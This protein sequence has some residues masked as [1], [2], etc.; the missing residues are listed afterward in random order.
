MLVIR[1]TFSSRTLFAMIQ[2]ET[3]LMRMMK[4]PRLMLLPLKRTRSLG[5]RLRVG[6]LS[7]FLSI[8]CGFM[9]D[10]FLFLSFF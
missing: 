8:V 4:I 10:L 5:L 3:S 6:S 7:P 2:R 1:A 9:T